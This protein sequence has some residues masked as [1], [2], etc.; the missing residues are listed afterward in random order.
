MTLPTRAGPQAG[1]VNPH[2]G[3]H[4]RTHAT[5]ASQPPPAAKSCD[6]L[7]QGCSDPQ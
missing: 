6:S 4:T 3:S 1:T 2:P 7:D 5:P